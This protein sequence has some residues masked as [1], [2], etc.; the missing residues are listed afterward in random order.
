ML[1]LECE[2][3]DEVAD[4]REKFKHFEN[5]EKFNLNEVIESSVSQ[6]CDIDQETPENCYETVGYDDDELCGS[7]VQSLVQH[8]NKFT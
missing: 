2:I 7:N 8:F 4:Q 1:K 3:L 6:H 5:I